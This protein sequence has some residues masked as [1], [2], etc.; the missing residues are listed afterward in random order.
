[1]GIH[2]ISRQSTSSLSTFAS[3]SSSLVAPRSVPP[4]R[5]H[6]STAISRSTIHLDDPYERILPPKFPS[7]EERERARA[8]L[9]KHIGSD[10]DIKLSLLPFWSVAYTF[11]GDVFYYLP[12]KDNSLIRHSVPGHPF[13]ITSEVCALRDPSLTTLQ[14]PTS[15]QFYL[16]GSKPPSPHNPPCPVLPVLNLEQ[17]ENQPSSL[18]DPFGPPVRFS[19]GPPR[20]LLQALYIPAPTSDVKKGHDIFS[21]PIKAG[22]TVAAPLKTP[23]TIR[24]MFPRGGTM[25]RIMDQPEG[26]DRVACPIRKPLLIAYEQGGRPVAAIDPISMTIQSSVIEE[27]RTSW[28]DMVRSFLLLVASRRRPRSCSS[29]PFAPNRFAAVD[30]HLSQLLSSHRWSRLQ[31]PD[32]SVHRISPRRRSCE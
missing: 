26:F 22:P 23:A 16:R 5:R 27:G 15:P 1:M 25:A 13:L 32:G 24:G 18:S 19:L 21:L 31:P 4:P 9:V 28:K 10:P 11:H 8:A 7:H 17:L 6:A 2:R 12:S 20:P 29:S 3:S 14:F 30:V